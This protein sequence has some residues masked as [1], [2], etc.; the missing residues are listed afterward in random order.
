MTPFARY[1]KLKDAERTDFRL[2]T[3]LPEH[4]RLYVD[5]DGSLPKV[6]Q[7]LRVETPLLVVEGDFGTGKSHLLRYVEHVLL[8]PD[9]PLVRFEPV[10][11]ALSGFHRRSNFLSVHQQIAPEF[12]K[13]A[14]AAMQAPG[15]EREKRLDGIH[16]ITENMRLALRDLGLPGVGTA[17]PGATT[18]KQWLMA[19]SKLSGPA[20]AKAKFTC[21]LFEEAGP[22]QIVELYKAISDLHRSVFG[23]KLLLLLDEAETF[24]NVVD[25]DA[26]ASI[27]SGMRTLFD[28]EN[29]SLGFFLGLN[30]PRVRGGIHP[31]LRSDVQSRIGNRQLRLKPLGTAEDRSQFMERLWPGLT[32]DANSLPFLLERAAFDLVA[33]RLEDLYRRLV[34]D[35]EQLFATSS[36]RDLL[37]VLSDIG[38]NA[39]EKGVEP[40]IRA[41]MIRRWYAMTKG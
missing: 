14:T 2:S 8:G 37:H 30:T 7:A 34:R 26:Q 40:P 16:G 31:L 3:K 39:V 22:T 12:I 25:I 6:E 19:S 41:D 10:Y 35:E 36:P 20:M 27:G 32:S 9:S 13:K 29:Q 1:F 23:K 38:L 33:H 15:K 11:V 17:H 21:T 4:L 28:S 5:L 18:A 24:S